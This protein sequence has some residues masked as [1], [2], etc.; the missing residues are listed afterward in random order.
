MPIAER[1]NVRIR[2]TTA[3][4]L[5]VEILPSN[6]VRS[7][8]GKRINIGEKLYVMHEPN[9]LTEYEVISDV[10]FLDPH[11]KEWQVI[12]LGASLP[13]LSLSVLNFTTNPDD[14]VR[15]WL[16]RHPGCTLEL[17]NAG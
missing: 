14:W 17:T 9:S 7:M 12:V 6:K 4:V 1:G 3:P 15:L 2:C 8:D 5:S 10:A 16:K 13:V 11:T